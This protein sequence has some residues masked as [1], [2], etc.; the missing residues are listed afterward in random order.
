M[1]CW[2]CKG[3]RAE[4]STLCAPCKDVAVAEGRYSARVKR[5]T[6]AERELMQA[7]RA[8]GLTCRA[9]ADVVGRSLQT[10]QRHTR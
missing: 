7:L 2:E 5:T 6:R 4:G 3:R 10:V 8:Q 9:V 1:I